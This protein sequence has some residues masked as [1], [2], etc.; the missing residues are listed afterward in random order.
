MATVGTRAY[1]ADVDDDEGI[2]RTDNEIRG[3]LACARAGIERYGFGD[4]L[5]PGVLER[6]WS[7]ARWADNA[8]LR[9]VRDLLEWVLGER[10]AG[11]LAGT[12]Y[13]RR[14]TPG[15]MRHELRLAGRVMLQGARIPVNPDWPPPQAAEA[16]ACTAEWLT[17]REDAPPAC[18]DG[19]GVYQCSCGVVEGAFPV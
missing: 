3:V 13:G 17:G 8:W 19:H 7:N 5:I 14:P 11:P 15:E 1:P 18:E 12:A 10:T 16:M 2:V 6:P 9:G 4:G